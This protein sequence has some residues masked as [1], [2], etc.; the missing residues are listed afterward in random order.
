[1]RLANALHSDGCGD[2]SNQPN[3]LRS[4]VLER[5]DGRRYTAAGGEHWVEE[6][7]LPFR[8]FTRNLEVVG[9]GLECFV[10]PVDPDMP[11]ACGR[12]QL[13]NSFDH[14]KTGTQNG[15]EGEFLSTDS[16]PFRSFE[17]CFDRDGLKLKVLGCLVRHQHRDFIDE[18]LENFRGRLAITEERE[19]VLHQGVRDEG[20]TALGGRSGGSGHGDDSTI[21]GDMKEYQAVILR[22][23]RR[24]REDEDALTDLLNERSRGGWEPAMMTQ[25]ESRMIIVFSRKAEQ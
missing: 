14:S 19:L 10:I 21:F 20:Q 15:H 8:R 6:K 9:D 2:E 7:E 3:T 4:G 18:L 12:H 17:W 16:E 11:D 22:L 5:V 25:D 13:E 24:T 1:M 23:T